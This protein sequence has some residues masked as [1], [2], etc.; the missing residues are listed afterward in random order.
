MVFQVKTMTATKPTCCSVEGCPNKYAKK[1]FCSTHYKKWRKETIPGYAE[2]VL[3]MERKRREANREK[4]RAASRRF[5][6]K[7]HVTLKPKVEYDP[8]AC[9]K[10]TMRVDELFALAGVRMGGSV[11]SGDGRAAVSWRQYLANLVEDEKIVDY[12][13]QADTREVTIFISK[14]DELA[15]EV[16]LNQLPPGVQKL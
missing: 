11:G 1:G 10:R 2:H 15:N 14:L 7:K 12:T 4:G 8:E 3:A 6:E 13:Y 16:D 9:I 5:N